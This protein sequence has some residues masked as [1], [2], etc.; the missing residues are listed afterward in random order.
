MLENKKSMLP[1]WPL[2]PLRVSHPICSPGVVLPKPDYAIMTEA[3]KENCE[4]LNLQ[5]TE[6][7]LDKILQVSLVVIL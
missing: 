7:F 3:I 6:V 2:T 1:I 5:L 4:K